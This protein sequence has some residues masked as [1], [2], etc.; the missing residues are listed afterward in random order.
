MGLSQH[1]DCV[2]I[3]AG[4]S[5]MMC[6]GT[7]AENG[8]RVVVVEKNKMAGR[9]LLITGKGRCNV[10]NNCDAATF[11]CKHRIKSEIYDEFILCVFK[12]GYDKI[13]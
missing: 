4:A 10:T 11:F 13:L 6:A 5:G 7:A 3:G 1:I 9:K 8:N 2:V 12:R